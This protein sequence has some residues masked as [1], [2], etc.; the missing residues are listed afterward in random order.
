MRKFRITFAPVAEAVYDLE[1]ESAEKAIS[2][3]KKAWREDHKQG[4]VQGVANL[5]RLV[6]PGVAES[7][8]PSAKT[9]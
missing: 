3:A 2:A 6:A 5:G 4:Q 1:A 9:A 7:E 8:V